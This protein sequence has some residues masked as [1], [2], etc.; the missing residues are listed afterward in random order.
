M[1]DVQICNMAL[2]RCT[3]QAAISDL[4][5]DHSKAASL[6]RTFYG[7]AR[8]AVLEDGRFSFSIF[9]QA[10]AAAVVENLSPYTYLYQ[11]P[12][13]PFCV[14]PLELLT[15][16]YVPSCLPFEVEGRLLYSN[17]PSAVLQYIG[18]VVDTAVFTPGFVNALAWRLAVELIG[19]L[20]GEAPDKAFSLY[21]EA[22]LRA[23]GADAMGSTEPPRP[24]PRIID[25]RFGRPMR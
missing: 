13:D 21:Q 16:Q 19:P 4:I 17:E 20:T 7:P 23:M 24:S 8:D 3:G 2:S 12:T 5:T 18:S 22:L 6:C 15:T 14:R 1:T 11:L 10:L 9:R 25:E